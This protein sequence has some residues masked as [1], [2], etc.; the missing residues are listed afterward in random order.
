SPV[1]ARSD[2][3]GLADL[4]VTSSRI[5]GAAQGVTSTL[6]CSHSE[7]QATP[8]ASELTR[9]TR[10][11]RIGDHVDALA[12]VLVARRGQDQDDA[13]AYAEALRD[14]GYES[15]VFVDCVA[16]ESG[17]EVDEA[18]RAGYRATAADVSVVPVD[19]E[20]IV[21]EEVGNLGDPWPVAA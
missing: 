12:G 3:L 5:N 4:A 13:E 16:A 21:R 11:N 1:T 9:Y 18:V 2:R 10:A 20:A 6:R 8:S 19:R 15:E 7:L 14:F 17:A